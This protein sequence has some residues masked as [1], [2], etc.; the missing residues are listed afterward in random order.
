MP[1][2]IDNG[3]PGILL[4][5]GQTYSSILPNLISYIDTCALMN[6]GNL[7][8]NQWIITTYPACVAEYTKFYDNNNAFQPIQL[9][10]AINNYDTPNQYDARRLTEII[11]YY[12]PYTSADVQS[13]LLYFGIGADVSVQSNIGLLK[14]RQW[15][16]HI[17]LCGNYMVCPFLKSLF[18][19]F[20][21]CTNPGLPSVLTFYALQFQQPP[22]T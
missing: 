11:N 2:D 5:I 3:L 8:P 17:E 16:C 1:L 20:F 18:P 14:L 4:K 19:L 6:T 15:N 13:I 7:L 21:E 10:V 22:S 12:P 9:Q